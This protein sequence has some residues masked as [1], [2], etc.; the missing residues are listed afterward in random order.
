MSGLPGALPQDRLR[1]CKAFRGSSPGGESF[2]GLPRPIQGPWFV[3]NRTR[4]GDA[5]AGY[6]CKSRGVCGTMCACMHACE[7]SVKAVLRQVGTFTL[8]SSLAKLRKT[9]HVDLAHPAQNS[10][11]ERDMHEVQ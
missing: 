2:P 8:P 7:G 4:T 1:C 5:Q 9:R 10:C 3:E 11:R 6:R